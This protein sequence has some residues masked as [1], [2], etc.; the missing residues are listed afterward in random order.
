MRTVA[1]TATAVVSLALVATVAAAQTDS[2]P[3][4]QRDMPIG[5]GMPQPKNGPDPKTAYEESRD[6]LAR[7]KFEAAIPL[8]Q[9][10]VIDDPRNDDAWNDLAFASQRLGRTGEAI[11]YYERALAIRPAR[12][13]TRER[14]GALQLALDNLPKAEEQLTELNK[15]CAT[16]CDELK[17]LQTEIAAYKATPHVSKKEI[18]K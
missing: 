18:V 13:D 8:L 10:I 15:L 3:F 6:L 11:G 9:A 2:I 4:P 7:E 5:L 1:W 16:A 14:L 12:K 17:S